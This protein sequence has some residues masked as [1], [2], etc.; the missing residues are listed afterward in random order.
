[1]IRLSEM[2]VSFLSTRL[3]NR[4]LHFAQNPDG[5]LPRA[6]SPSRT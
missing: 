2:I 3:Q 5:P 6:P 1:M 4:V